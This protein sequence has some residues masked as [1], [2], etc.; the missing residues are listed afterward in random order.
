MSIE[1][2]SR[3]LVSTH[4]PNAA[5]PK[6]GP[7]HHDCGHVGRCCVNHTALRVTNSHTKPACRPLL[8]RV[9]T[10]RPRATVSALAATSSARRSFGHY[11]FAT[12]ERV[13][14]IRPMFR[15]WQQRPT[16]WARH[17]ASANVLSS[18]HPLVSGLASSVRVASL[19]EYHRVST[20]PSAPR[21]TLDGMHM[22]GG[23]L[24]AD[25]HRRRL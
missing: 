17:S 3:S 6:S 21:R 16:S 23:L 11:R 8:S 19:R 13:T 1:Y 5:C 24:G 4:P 25:P 7:R 2:R 22:F 15:R 9:R 12:I 10:H 18:P 20:P 14:A